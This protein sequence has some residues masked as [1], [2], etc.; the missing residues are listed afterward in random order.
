MAGAW[1]RD[2]ERGLWPLGGEAGG[3]EVSEPTS[4]GRFR[5]SRVVGDVEVHNRIRAYRLD[6]AADL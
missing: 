1:G 5:D 4:Q 6:V 3:S 2:V